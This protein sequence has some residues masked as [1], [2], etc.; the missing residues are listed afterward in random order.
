MIKTDD[1]EKVLQ[2]E[3]D[4]A[5]AL[6]GVLV[7][8]QQS[9]V[10]FNG[11]SLS[12]LT[13]REQDL[14]GPFRALEKERVRLAGDLAAAMPGGSR[15]ASPTPVNLRDLVSALDRPTAARVDT[16][17]DRLRQAVVR[18]V[19]LNDQNRVLMRHSLKFVRETM[20]IITQDNTRNLVD[21]KM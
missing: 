7:Q 5:E 9:M 13:Q 12:S 6:I 4:L 16:H 19:A 21:Q 2:T 14:L 3:A 20:R 8:K 1:L 17:A 11:E 18:I 15:S 10:R